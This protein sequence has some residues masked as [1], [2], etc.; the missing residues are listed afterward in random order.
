MS[1][2]MPDQDD[3]FYD[4]VPL[5]QF[6]TYRLARL[7]AKLNAQASRILSDHA[8]ITLGQWRVIALTGGK[9]EITLTEIHRATQMDKGQLSRTIKGMFDDELITS[10]TSEH[11]QRQ[12]ILL[13]SQKG[14]DIYRHMLPIMRE[15][16]KMLMSCLAAEERRIIF[17]AIDKLEIAADRPVKPAAD[18]PGQ[19]L[20]KKAG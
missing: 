5:Q 4:G 7:H 8:G 17:S 18:L 19:L 13:L 12:Q 14:T 9:G 11:D 3:S 20:R 10:R 2:V 16:Q 15:R 6:L 1:N